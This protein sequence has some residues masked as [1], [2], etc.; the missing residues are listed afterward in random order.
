MIVCAMLLARLGE[1]SPRAP[2]YW[3]LV[4]QWLL[5]LFGVAFYLLLAVCIYRAAKYFGAAGKEQKLLRIEMGKLA[6]EVNLLRQE[7]KDSKNT[8]SPAQAI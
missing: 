7:M 8:I 1:Y 6:E 3:L 2:G 5:P 4:L